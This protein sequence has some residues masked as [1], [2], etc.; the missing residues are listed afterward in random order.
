MNLAQFIGEYNIGVPKNKP[1]LALEI[2]IYNEAPRNLEYEI[3]LTG[4]IFYMVSVIINN[5]NSDDK[6]IHLQNFRGVG[7]ALSLSLLNLVDKINAEKE[8]YVPKDL[9]NPV[10]LKL[11]A[12]DFKSEKCIFFQSRQDYKENHVVFQG[13]HFYC[14]RAKLRERLEYQGVS[15]N[16]IKFALEGGN[17]NRI[18][19]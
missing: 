12:G 19:V 5:I 13:T 16:E 6:Q 15:E 4:P 10:Y 14:L 9:Y 18:Y 17:I 1:T 3:T 2:N 8:I 7:K 11:L